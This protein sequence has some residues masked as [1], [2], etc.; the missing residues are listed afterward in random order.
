MFLPR[1]VEELAHLGLLGFV[2]EGV[3]EGL[4]D[5]SQF[6]NVLFGVFVVGFLIFEPMG[7]YGIWIRVRNYWKAF[8]FSY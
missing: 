5:V 2:G 6:S 8:P 3:G 1:F 4:L 7:L